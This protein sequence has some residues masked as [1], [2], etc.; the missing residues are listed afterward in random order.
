MQI[1]KLIQI[2]FVPLIVIIG[3]SHVMVLYHL[4]APNVMPPSSE[5]ILILMELVIANLA[6][7]ILAQILENNAVMHVIILFPGVQFA[8]LL[9][10]VWNASLDM[11]LI[12]MLNVHALQ[13]T[14]FLD[15]VQ[16]SLDVLVLYSIVVLFGVLPAIKLYI[17]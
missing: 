17:L 15:Y 4:I 1:W 10:F 16:I 11:L 3:V 14:L 7:W 12:I 8:L 5:L 13:A 6:T 2:Y 9:P